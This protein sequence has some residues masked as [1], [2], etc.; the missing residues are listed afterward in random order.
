M[1]VRNTFY[2]LVVAVLLNSFAY[3]VWANCHESHACEDLPADL[4]DGWYWEEDDDNEVEYLINAHH[5]NRR[6]PNL[7]TDVDYGA[8]YWHRLEYDG[9]IAEIGLV[10]NNQYTDRRPNR[11]DGYNVVG[12]GRLDW[13]EGDRVGGACYRRWYD[14]TK[15]LYDCDIIINYQAPFDT[16]GNVDSDEICLRNTATHEFGHFIGL[17]DLVPRYVG[18]RR[19]HCSEYE[20]YT[21][22]QPT[23]VGQGD[24]KKHQKETIECEEKWVILNEVYPPE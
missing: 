19:R 24:A 12:W 16:H 21:M 11:R 22:W 5:Y 17:E 18:G 14:G 9:E 2:V 3:D 7:T 15:R 4:W 1:L 6:L 13:E 8:S 23:Y 20:R 10:R